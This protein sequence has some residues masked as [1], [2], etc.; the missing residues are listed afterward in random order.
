MLKLVPYTASWRDP[1]DTFVRTSTKNG[2]LLHTRQFLSHHPLNEAQDASLLFTDKDRIV[3]VLP[4][5]VVETANGS[6]LVSHPR[7]TYGSFVVDTNLGVKEAVAI[8]ELAVQHA[9]SNGH[10][11]MVV[12]NPFRIFNSVPSDEIDYAL[13]KAGF[14]IDA[15]MV[16]IALPLT[17]LTPDTLLATYTKATRNRL[18]KAL[19][20]PLRFEITDRYADFWAILE[21]NLRE[22][23]GIR[24]AHDLESIQRL[25]AAVGDEA[26]QLMAAFLDDRMIAGLVLF[27]VNAFSMHAQYIAARADATEFCPTNGLIHRVALQ[28]LASGC[29]FFNLGTANTEGGRGLNESLFYFKEG[30]GGRGVLREVMRL[31]L[32]P[33]G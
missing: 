4:A 20:S 24:P 1:W 13:W 21:E 29:H 7:A 19:A 30:F 22:R 10:R 18:R 9:A 12:R 17:G 26:V 14:Q 28:A 5:A 16:E 3:A 2:T 32:A 25:R 8:V 11:S 27:R 15:R 23:H 31:E 6:S 33:A